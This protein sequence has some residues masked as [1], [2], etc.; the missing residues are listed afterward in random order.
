MTDKINRQLRFLESRKH[1]AF[2]RNLSET[3]WNA[4]EKEIQ[5]SSLSY[6]ERTTLRLKRFLEIETPVILE[7][8]DIHGLRTIIDFPDIYSVGEMDEIKKT[9]YVHEKGKITNLA[10]DVE[11]VLKEGLE[12]RRTRLLGG[13]KRDPDF[14]R[15]AEETIDISIAFVDKYAAAL[16]EAGKVEDAETYKRI[17]RSGA[18]TMKE[19]LQLFRMLHFILWATSC[20]HNTVGRFDIWLYP[21]YKANKACGMSDEE[22]LEIIEDFFLSFNRD[23]DLYYGLSQGDNGQSL[24]LGGVDK[25]GKNVVN[26]LTPLTLR[27]RFV[28]SI[29][30]SIFVLTRTLPLSFTK[31]QPSSPKSVLASLN[32]PTMISLSPAFRIGATI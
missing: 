31:R 10:W 25:D 20:Y 28:K 17:I 14:C 26:E 4:V 27:K 6:I 19:A 23:S 8:T 1:R 11:K 32:I 5:N 3:E 7:D 2:R 30:K 16:E 18:E 12:G 21:F 24:V 15:F 29:L 13:E 9:H 22:A